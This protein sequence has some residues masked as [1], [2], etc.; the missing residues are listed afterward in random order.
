MGL[1]IANDSHIINIK[2]FQCCSKS[3]I[4]NKF[5]PENFLAMTLKKTLMDSTIHCNNVHR[6]LNDTSGNIIRINRTWIAKNI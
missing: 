2:G 6:K 1:F 5:P 3:A 4:L